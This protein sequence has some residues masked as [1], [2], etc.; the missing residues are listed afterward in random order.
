MKLIGE[1]K[2]GLVYIYSILIF[3]AIL[4]TFIGIKQVKQLTSYSLQ[5]RT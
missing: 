2:K 3:L 4:I 5:N 1:K